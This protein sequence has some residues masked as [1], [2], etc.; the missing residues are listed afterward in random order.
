MTAPV[1]MWK[2]RRAA[3]TV[4]VWRACASG[5]PCLGGNSTSAARAARGPGFRS[6]CPGSD[7]PIAAPPGQPNMPKIKILLV[8]DHT[9]FRHAMRNLL[10]A[11]PDMEVVAEAA[12][13]SEA[14]AQAAGSHPD[15]VLLDIGM[16]GL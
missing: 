6:A 7:V 4:L 2:G 8:D 12:N 1:S 11:E 10:A 13:A 14:L 15:V 9:L 16:Q 3:G 5:W